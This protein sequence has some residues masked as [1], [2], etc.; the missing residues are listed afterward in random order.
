MCYLESGRDTLLFALNHQKTPTALSIHLYFEKGTYRA[1]DLTNG[2][3]VETT[4][5]GHGIV[6]HRELA[7][8]GVWI[9]KSPPRE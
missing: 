6:L 4:R 5:G 9:V 2:R 8:S 7:P 1:T 3:A